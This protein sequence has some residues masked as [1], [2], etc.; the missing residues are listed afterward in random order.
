M[1]GVKKSCREALKKLQA[2]SFK[3]Q[4]ERKKAYSS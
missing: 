4:A 1:I 3:L 2:T